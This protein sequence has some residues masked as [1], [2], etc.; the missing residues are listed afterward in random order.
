MRLTHLLTVL[1]ALSSA[2]PALAYSATIEIPRPYVVYLQDGKS[3]KTKALDSQRQ[4]NLPAGEHQLVIRFEGSFKDQSENRLISGE[5]VVL[6]LDL[7]AEDQLAIK[8]DYPK[9]YRAAEKFL[10][11]Q[12][13]TFI[14]TQSGGTTKVDYFVM[15][16]KEGLQIGR[17]YQQELQALGKAFQQPAAMTSTTEMAVATVAGA[18]ATQGATSG[19]GALDKKTQTLEM[20][21]YWY[22]QAD[23]E[24]RKNFQYW[25]ISQQ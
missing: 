19:K 22:N 24:T 9:N 3:A 21:K 25:V 15:P 18:A 14:D 1:C 12:D 6:N 4:F 16:K 23:A 20:L 13:L 2:L 8:F 7:K 11:K 10:E 17:D 5:P